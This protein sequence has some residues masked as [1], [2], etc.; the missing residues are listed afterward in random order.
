MPERD[1]KLAWIGLPLTQLQIPMPREGPTLLTPLWN[2]HLLRA[3]NTMADDWEVSFGCIPQ[4]TDRTTPSRYRS[5]HSRN[6]L[7]RSLASSPDPQPS[8]LR[9]RHRRSKTRTR[10]TTRRSLLLALGPLGRREK[11]TTTGSAARSRITASSGIQRECAHLLLASDS[12]HNPC[13]VFVPET[14]SWWE[15][16]RGRSWSGRRRHS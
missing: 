12:S 7:R 1:Q 4:L 6:W 14:R 9:Q 5:R 2:P 3:S 11:A 13:P 16:E 10:D 15:A 8:R